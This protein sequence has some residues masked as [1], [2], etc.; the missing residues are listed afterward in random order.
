RDANV[1][2]VDVEISGASTVAL[3]I[4]GVCQPSVVASDIRDNPGAAL[5]I[6]ASASPRIMHNVF[7][8]NGLSTAASGAI[9]LDPSAEPNMSGNISHG[10]GRAACGALPDAVRAAILRD[11]W[12]PEGD[13]ARPAESRTPRGRGPQ[14]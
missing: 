1:S 11:N 6:R 2:I 9:D 10:V 7:I 4:G 14:R 13:T 12:F 8:R 5:T 3:E